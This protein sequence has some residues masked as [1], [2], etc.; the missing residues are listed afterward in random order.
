MPTPATVMNCCVT[1][2]A[3]SITGKTNTIETST[4]KLNARQRDNKNN[5]SI[6]KEINKLP[7]MLFNPDSN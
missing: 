3:E 1:N 7:L 6:N 4:G 5:V 2:A